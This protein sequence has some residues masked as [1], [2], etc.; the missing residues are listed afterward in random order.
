MRE[1]YF[2]VVVV[3]NECKA[4]SGERRCERETIHISPM[5]ILAML[6]WTKFKILASS[7]MYTEIFVRRRRRGEI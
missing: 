6:Y 7:V 1:Q 2:V 5:I 4:L 3:S